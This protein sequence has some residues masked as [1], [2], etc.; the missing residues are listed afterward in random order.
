MVVIPLWLLRRSHLPCQG[1]LT[2]APRSISSVSLIGIDSG[3]IEQLAYGGIT[4]ILQTSVTLPV[5][6]LKSY[7]VVSQ[8]FDQFRYFHNSLLCSS[9]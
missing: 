7:E 8:S 4:H 3:G 5:F 6:Y 2:R 9:V 1:W